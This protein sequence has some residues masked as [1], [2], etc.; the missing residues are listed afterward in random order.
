M[1]SREFRVEASAESMRLDA[2]LAQV[3]PDLSRSRWARAILEGRVRVDGEVADPSDRVRGGQRVEYRPPESRSAGTLPLFRG[4]HPTIL[5]ED[6]EMM[7]LNKPCGL[8]VHPGHGLELEETLVGWALAE[9]KLSGLPHEESENEPLR[10]GIVHRLDRV[11]SGAIVVAKTPRAQTELSAQ[12]AH[13]QAGRLYWAVV[14]GDVK[15]LKQQRPVAFER[16]LKEVPP[17]AALRFSVEAGSEV[18]SVASHLQR[19]PRERTRFW[20]SRSG[21]GKRAVTHMTSISHSQGYSLVECK[22]QTGRTHQIRVHMA[23]LGY[24]ILGDALYGGETHRRVWLHAH[25]LRLMDW[26]T[27]EER[28]FVAPW[29]EEDED[30]LEENGLECQSRRALWS[31]WNSLKGGLEE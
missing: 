12:F 20:V 11:T 10:T 19:D 4:L 23:S 26:R 3:A 1:D 22:L 21:A 31:K 14:K 30:W 28:V 9:G 29:P 7:V 2:F 27:G 8:S 5:F 15:L 24:P 16:L 6:E 18:I 25:E 13:R 17:R